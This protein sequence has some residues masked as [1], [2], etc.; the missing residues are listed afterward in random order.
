[1]VVEKYESQWAGL[2]HILWKIKNVWNHQ[3]VISL[4]EHLNWGLNLGSV[5]FIITWNRQQWSYVA[6]V[7]SN[8]P[9]LFLVKMR[10]TPNKSLY[11]VRTLQIPIYILPLYTHI[12]YKWFKKY[13][14]II[15]YIYISFQNNYHRWHVPHTSRC[16]YILPRRWARLWSQWPLRHWWR[17]PELIWRTKRTSN[18]SKKD[19]RASDYHDLFS[20][21]SFVFIFWEL[22]WVY[23][24]L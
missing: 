2:S 19:S 3:P 23:Y 16:R 18:D 22:T 1:M 20:G 6:H 7:W 14:Y 13:I 21:I 10:Q 8:P 11:L 15:I 9:H 17:P 24:S 5:W 4:H 12:I